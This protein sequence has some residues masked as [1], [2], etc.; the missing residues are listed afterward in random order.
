M[1]CATATGS[2][3]KRKTNTS[4]P[5]I[6]DLKGKTLLDLGCG[7]GWHCGYAR[8]QG[9]R[10]ILGI[11]LSEKMLMEARQRNS[12]VPIT[13]RECAIEDY[14]RPPRTGRSLCSALGR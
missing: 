9:A 7:Y 6:P 3:L 5:C 13:Y 12:G 1:N 11:D 10:E 14:D 4:I 2:K 8:E